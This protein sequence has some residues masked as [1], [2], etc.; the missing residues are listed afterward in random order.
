MEIHIT[1][2]LLGVNTYAPL[3]VFGCIIWYYRLLC[4]CC[5][6]FVITS[7]ICI[8]WHY[9]L[10]SFLHIEFTYVLAHLCWSQCS[11]LEDFYGCPQK[12]LDTQ[13]DHRWSFFQGKKP[14][15]RPSVA[16]FRKVDFVF[17]PLSI[18]LSKH[19]HLGFRRIGEISRYWK[20]QRYRRVVCLGWK[21]SI[22]VGESVRN[23]C[24]EM[25]LK[26]AMTL[27]L[28]AVRLGHWKWLAFWGWVV[29]GVA[30]KKKGMNRKDLCKC[31]VVLNS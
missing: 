10:M 29:Y 2:F 7:F 16:T 18:Y 4:E 26:D 9:R 6:F 19:E 1:L 13:L 22:S 14:S 11:C 20:N 23:H 3:V 21:V 24:T 31:V 25:D 28:F 30:T 5:V 17:T 15:H 12:G 8:T 27:K